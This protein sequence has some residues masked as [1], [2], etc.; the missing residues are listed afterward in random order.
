MTLVVED[1]TGKADAESYISVSDAT[2][3]HA[4]RG[5]S[6]WAAIASDT[7]REQLL[8]KATDYMLYTYRGSW[9]GERKT[10]AQ[11][12][13]WPRYSA[14]PEDRQTELPD[15]EVPQDIAQA[16]AELALIANTTSLTPS[17][18]RGKKKV[19]VGPLEVEY[20][21][22]APTATAFVAASVRLAYYLCGVANGGPF[23]K[24]VRT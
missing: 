16:C 22:S 14:W 17:V 21:G 15:D 5:N 20:D 24:L 18:T 13:D 3:Y 19:K 23:A 1:G 8:R 11:R 7:V 10:D 6:A 2:A 9:L 12:L 4:S